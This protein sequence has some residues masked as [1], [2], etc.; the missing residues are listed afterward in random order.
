M[1]CWK[2]NAEFKILIKS[3]GHRVL[4]NVVHKGIQAH[5][6]HISVYF[7]H[8][9]IFVIINVTVQLEK[10][11]CRVMLMVQLYVSSLMMKALGINR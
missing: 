8:C 3:L 6:I 9:S 11:S 1:H 2:V 10:D 4:F 7:K 5:I